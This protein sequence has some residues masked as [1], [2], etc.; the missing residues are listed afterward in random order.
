MF[1]MTYDAPLRSQRT[2][3]EMPFHKDRH[4][5]RKSL[6]LLTLAFLL[7]FGGYAEARVWA[8]AAACGK[9]ITG[10]AGGMCQLTPEAYYTTIY[11]MSVCTLDPMDEDVLDRSTCELIWSKTAGQEVDPVA[12]RSGAQTLPGTVS[13]PKNGTYGFMMAVLSKKIG[14]KFSL[15]IEGSSGTDGTYYTTATKFRNNGLGTTDVASYATTTDDIYN[16]DETSDKVCDPKIEVDMG[17]LGYVTAW[18]VDSSLAVTETFEEVEIIGNA[19][20]GTYTAHRCANA[21]KLL[22]V[23][24]LK[25]AI[26]VSNKTS[27]INLALKVTDNAGLAIDADGDGDPDALQTGPWVGYITATEE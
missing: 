10:G 18:L 19:A 7:L 22:G 12:M 23:T 3:T 24:E 9:V 20:E 11:E 16:F 14:T 1:F 5:S 25:K 4:E 27:S 21:A 2:L 17:A 15:E 13:R 8:T 26:T 6:L